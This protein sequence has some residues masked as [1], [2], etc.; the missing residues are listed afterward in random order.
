MT[1]TD[2]PVETKRIPVPKNVTDREFWLDCFQTFATTLL[3]AKLE[4]RK[5]SMQ[6]DWPVTTL[7][8]SIRVAAQLADTALEEALYRQW[9]ASS[10]EK[11]TETAPRFQS[12]AEESLFR[13]WASQKKKQP[14]RTKSTRRKR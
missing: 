12:D 10:Q 14:T 9:V 13:K 5:D 1:E 11:P 8:E 7:K 4:D 3:D 2:S 6:M